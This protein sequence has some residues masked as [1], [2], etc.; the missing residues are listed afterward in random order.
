MCV[1]AGILKD[2][3][4]DDKLMFISNGDKHNYPFYELKQ[5]NSNKLIKI[6]QKSS[7]FSKP[8][9]KTML[10]TSLINRPMSPPSLLCKGG[11]RFV[12]RGN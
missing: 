2:K 10:G 6:A 3:I 1:V 12:V 9:N 5:T 4:L 11:E 8:R 7:K